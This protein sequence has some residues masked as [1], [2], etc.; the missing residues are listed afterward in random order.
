MSSRVNW[1]I[2]KRR[3]A[4]QGEKENDTAILCSYDFAAVLYEKEREA[5]KQRIYSPVAR[6]ALARVLC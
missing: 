2:T 5:N 1:R 6:H 3:A 4:F